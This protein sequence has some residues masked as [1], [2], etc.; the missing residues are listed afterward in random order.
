MKKYNLK[1]LKSKLFQL[2]KIDYGFEIYNKNSECIRFSFYHLGS[3]YNAFCTTVFFN[4]SWSAP[5]IEWQYAK[6]NKTAAEL[7]KEIVICLLAL[8]NNAQ[9]EK[10]VEYYKA[11]SK[12]VFNAK[13][14]IETQL[15]TFDD[16]SGLK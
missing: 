1:Y 15:H 7:V 4:G 6:Q 8:Q 9:A 10:E 13:Y 16:W 11:L 14:S 12:Q 3:V 2:V 5:R